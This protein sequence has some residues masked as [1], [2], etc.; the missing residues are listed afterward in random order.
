MTAVSTSRDESLILQMVKGLPLGQR[1]DNIHP[2]TPPRDPLR[3]MVIFENDSESMIFRPHF[4]RDISQIQTIKHAPYL[5]D[6]L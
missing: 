2:P 4:P 3:S 1:G 6:W 5:W